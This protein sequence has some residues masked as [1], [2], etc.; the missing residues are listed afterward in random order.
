MKHTIT[1]LIATTI[2]TA[3]ATPQ[4][5][6][7]TQS[8]E[9]TTSAPITQLKPVPYPEPNLQTQFDQLALQ[10]SKLEHQIEQLQT[11]VRQ[12]EQRPATPRR[13]IKP[14]AAPIPVSG[15]LK[16]DK[17]LSQLDEAKQAYR[18]GNYQAVLNQLRG[19]DSGGNGSNDAREAM[20]LLLQSHQRLDNCQSVINIGQRYA[21]HYAQQ[22]QAD[23]ALY[24]V[25]QCQWQIQQRDIARDTWQKLI[26]IYPNSDAAR[27]AAGRLK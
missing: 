26:R 10:V 11:R 17:T 21:I 15:S 25:G 7:A 8:P 27:R 13:N 14:K 23:D 4:T 22:E 12:L 6:S 9:Q 18:Q 20:Y 19:A 16:S 24:A 2:L 5:P 1:L 3:C